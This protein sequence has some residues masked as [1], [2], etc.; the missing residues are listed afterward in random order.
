[1]YKNI[2]AIILLVYAVFGEGLLDYLDVVKKPEPNPAAEI[3]DIVKPDE[4]VIKEVKSFSEIVTEPSDRAK[5]AIFNY[6]FAERVLNYDSTVQQANDVYALAGK[7]FFKDS[8]V[9]KYDGLAEKIKYILVK[10]L[11]NDNHV[12]TQKEKQD[13]NKYFMGIA[14]SLIQKG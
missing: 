1:M 11:T 7:L 13:L 12:I 10:I 5:L 6:E 3:L 8:M 4:E 14:W 9:D 2:L